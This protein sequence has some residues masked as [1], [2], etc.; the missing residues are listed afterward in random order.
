MPSQRQPSISRNPRRLQGHDHEDLATE[1]A[2]VSSLSAN[3][4]MN[5]QRMIGNQ[6]VL[7]LMRDGTSTTLQRKPKTEMGVK[8][9]EVAPVASDEKSAAEMAQ[10]IMGTQ[11]AILEGWATALDNFD[12]VMTSDSDAAGKANFQNVLYSFLEDKVVGELFKRS[13]LP[14]VGDAF[15][16]MNKMDGEL[17]RAQAA[18]DSASLRGFYVMYRTAIGKL[19]QIILSTT[20]DFVARV[21]KA[22]ES[23][24]VNQQ[25]AD[26]YGMLRLE[27]ENTLNA[28]DYQ[29]KQSAPETIY[30]LLTEQWLRDSTVRLD[31]V[32]VR[33]SYVFIRL[34]ADYSVRDAHIF[35]VGGQ[36][37]AEQL[38]RDAPG[39][40]DVY[41][42][43]VPRLVHYFKEGARG[44]STVLKVDERGFV[45]NRNSDG[46]YRPLHSRLQQQ[47]LPPTKKITGE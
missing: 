12:K 33:A 1:S 23:A 10:D 7:R 27:L 19:R 9:A 47:G 32:G 46:N 41:S 6:A 28:L 20:A 34:E 13:K 36:K 11:L 38:I 45:D 25:K 17:K 2:N 30:R 40:I 31:Q 16:L 43:K 8:P 26:E 3:G 22:E 44:A 39:G 4:I 18:K 37:L 5:L 21:R 14:G 35:G 42:M 15:A 24:G 29:L